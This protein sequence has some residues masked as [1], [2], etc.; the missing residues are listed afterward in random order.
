MK[1]RKRKKIGLNLFGFELKLKVLARKIRK[2]ALNV[3]ISSAR[4]PVAPTLI[5][6]FSDF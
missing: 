6:S 2:E 3:Y 4:G 5:S 1:M